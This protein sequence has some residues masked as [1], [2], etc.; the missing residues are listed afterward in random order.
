MM[1]ELSELLMPRECL[2]C[3]RKLGSH[4][5]HLC[6]WCAADV[7]QTFYWERTHNPMA[8]E[9]NAI[10]ERQRRPGVSMRYAWASALLFYHHENPYKMIPRAVKYCHNLSAG[11]F[12]A[13][14][15]G[16]KMAA[17]PHW[18]DVDTVIPVPLHWTRQWRRGYNQAEVIAACLAR[19]LGA[20]LRT[21]IL[22]RSRSTHTQTRLDAEDRLKN[23]MGVF[24]VR[25]RPLNAA[26]V[27]VVDDTFTTG[28]TLAAC[29][30]ALRQALGPEVRISVTTLSVVEA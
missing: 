16:R 3:G 20:R 12:F 8:D 7:P 19:A 23:V 25:K 13:Q 17:F 24:R 28:A 26:H 30:M 6:I 11:Q 4:E 14:Q 27:L 21:D 29:Y 15:L 18:A 5:Q 10:L 1:K 22:Y 2:V 9:F